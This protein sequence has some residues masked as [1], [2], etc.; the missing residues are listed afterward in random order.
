MTLSFV[1][2]IRNNVERNETTD[3]DIRIGV[4]L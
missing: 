1:Q 4:N 2:I 3:N